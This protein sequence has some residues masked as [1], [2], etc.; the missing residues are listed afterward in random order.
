MISVLLYFVFF[1]GFFKINARRWGFSTIFLSL[2][3]GFRTFFVPRG[4]RIRPL[5]I[6]Q[7]FAREGWSGLQLTD[8]LGSKG[9]TYFTGTLNH[10]QTVY[11]YKQQEDINC[12]ID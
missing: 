4:W 9:L 6:P 5:K 10:Q 8:T 12:L 3:S 2:G 7:E 11:L 1:A